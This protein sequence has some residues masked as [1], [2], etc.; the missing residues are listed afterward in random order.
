M[1]EVMEFY[2]KMG[3]MAYKKFEEAL[4]DPCDGITRVLKDWKMGVGADNDT[5]IVAIF[6]RT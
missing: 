2:D 3:S 4:N 5:V 6:E 1:F